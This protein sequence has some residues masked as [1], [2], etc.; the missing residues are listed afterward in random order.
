MAVLS[1]D[2]RQKVWRGIMRYWSGQREAIAGLD[3]NDLRSAVDNTDQWIETNEGSFNSALP[4][5][6]QTNLTTTQKTMLFTAVALM[7]ADPELA[8]KILGVLE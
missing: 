4:A 6:A 7:R 2:D 1:E 5:A 3:K 8:K